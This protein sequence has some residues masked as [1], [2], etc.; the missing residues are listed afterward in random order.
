MNQKKLTLLNITI[1]LF[2]LIHGCV[3]K[4]LRLPSSINEVYT[5]SDVQQGLLMAANNNIL[6]ALSQDSLTEVEKTEVDNFC[7]EYEVPIWS[8]KLSVYLN[9]LRQHPEWFNKF[10]VLEIKKGDKAEVQLQSDGDEAKILSITYLMS[11][12]N[13]KITY[14]TKLPCKASLA[15]YIEKNIKKTIY[16]FPS[17]DDLDLVL[18][19]ASEKTKVPR[20]QFNNAFLIYLAERGVIYKFTH[21]S[22]FEKNFKKKYVMA[23]VLNQLSSEVRTAGNQGQLG[24][25]N[26]FIKKI[27]QNSLQSEL[28]QLFGVQSDQELKSGVKIDSLGEYARKA[29]G[30]PDITYLFLTYKSENDDVRVTSLLSLE[31]CLKKKADEMGSTLRRP[32]T[33]DEK[34]NFLG[35]GFVCL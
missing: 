14:K 4:D 18:D 21:E 27:H 19:K 3:S 34:Q 23:E 31:S 30:Q 25:L 11:E 13:D 28:I 9:K 17:A 26:L 1:G 16:D 33:Q 8:Q 12:V 35:P 32:A 15:E 6:F 29:L 10:H 24:H 20:F 22:S 7:K 2:V 5:Q